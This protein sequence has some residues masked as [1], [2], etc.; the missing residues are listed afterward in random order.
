[1]N[2]QV[3]S[4]DLLTGTIVMDSGTR[5]RPLDNADISGDFG[6]LNDILTA[7]LLGEEAEVQADA[8]FENGVLRATSLMSSQL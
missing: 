8:F 1:M 6:S 7:L 2:G 4:V 5:V 3:D